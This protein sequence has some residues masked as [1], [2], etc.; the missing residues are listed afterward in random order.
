MVSSMG[1]VKL[2]KNKGECFDDSHP[3]YKHRFLFFSED[4]RIMVKDSKDSDTHMSDE[5]ASV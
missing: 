2:E 1:W 5:S 3:E 4:E